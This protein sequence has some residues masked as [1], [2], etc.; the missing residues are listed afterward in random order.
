MGGALRSLGS[1]REREHLTEPV[2]RVRRLRD[3][4]SSTPPPAFRGLRLCKVCSEARGWPCCSRADAEFLAK[5][6]RRFHTL[7]EVC[8]DLRMNTHY[9]STV[10]S[11]AYM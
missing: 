5:L 4:F 11:L 10:G 3:S 8:H 1:A 6:S 7:P 9:P 2:C